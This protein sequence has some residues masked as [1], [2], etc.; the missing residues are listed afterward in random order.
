MA[1]SFILPTL[2]SCADFLNEE[3]TTE[4]NT[5]YFN[6]NEGVEALTTGIYYNLRFHFSF[7]W[8][9]S[10]TNYGTDEFIVGGDGSNAMWNSYISSLNSDIPTVNINT[11][12]AYDVWDNM[13]TG[14]ASANLLIEKCENYTGSMKNEALGTAHFMRGFNYFKLV[15][16]YGGVPI[17]LTTS[18]TVER[19]FSRASAQ[20]V[21]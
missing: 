17:K 12:H 1:G 2:N 13:Y 10:T 18:N 21:I 11:T 5:E 16:Q 20:E 6:T 3:L 7:E 8:G 15:C 4:Q 19:E 14:I 9:F